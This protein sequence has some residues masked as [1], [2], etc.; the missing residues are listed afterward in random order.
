[1]APMAG[2]PFLTALFTATSAACVNGRVVEETPQYWSRDGQVVILCLFQVG[3]LGI[4]AFGA[5]FG[6]LA[7]RNIGVREHATL[8]DIL[9]S[10]GLGN[11]RRLVMAILGLTFSLE[12]I[13]AVLLS[14]LWS[15][16]P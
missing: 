8:G 5:F 6:L 11:V 13:G 7:G 4:M 16:Q 2:A 12:L 14:G 3:G 9:E 1:D 10:E 15:D